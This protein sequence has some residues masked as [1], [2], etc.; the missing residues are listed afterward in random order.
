[1]KT[2]Y[3]HSTIQ[4]DGASWMPGNVIR[5]EHTSG[6]MGA[7]NADVKPFKEQRVMA[8]RS[9]IDAARKHFGVKSSSLTQP[10]TPE[11]NALLDTDKKPNPDKFPDA[12]T[13]YATSG[14]QY[15][16]DIRK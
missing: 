10:G 16:A 1:M 7:Q 8:Y 2:A 12:G 14:A 11:T 13:G 3:E 15:G 5:E 6:G 9:G 4:P